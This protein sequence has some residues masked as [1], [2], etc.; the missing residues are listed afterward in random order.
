MGSGAFKGRWSRYVPV[1]AA[2]AAAVPQLTTSRSAASTAAPSAEASAPLGY[3]EASFLSADRQ[4]AADAAADAPRLIVAPHLASASIKVVKK[5]ALM[6]DRAAT[7]QC[8]EKQDLMELLINRLGV[9]RANRQAFEERPDV[10]EA[11]AVAAMLQRMAAESR[12]LVAAM[13]ERHEYA[14]VCL[15]IAERSDSSPRYRTR[16]RRAVEEAKDQVVLV[17]LIA[18]DIELEATELCMTIE[19][20][21]DNTPRDRLPPVKPV[22]DRSLRLLGSLAP[23]AQMLSDFRCWRLDGAAAVEEREQAFDMPSA[24]DTLGASRTWN[25]EEIERLLEAHDVG[26]K[27]PRAKMEDECERLLAE[28]D[29]LLAQVEQAELQAESAELLAELEELQQRHK[30]EVHDVEAERAQ[31]AADL[32]VLLGEQ[33][34]LNREL[35]RQLATMCTILEMVEDERH[36]QVMEVRRL[37]QRF[38]LETL[39]MTP[40][41]LRCAGAML[42]EDVESPSAGLQFKIHPD[43]IDFNVDR[44]FL[45]AG[46]QGVVRKGIMKK[47][48]QEVAVKSMTL[49][50]AVKRAQLVSEIEGLLQAQGC[51]Y[52]VQWVGRFDT[53]LSLTVHVVLEYMDLGSLSDLKARRKNRMLDAPWLWNI[54]QQMVGGLDFLHGKRLLHR[55]IKPQNVLYNSSGEVKLTDFG[56][57]KVMNASVAANTCVGTSLYLSPERCESEEYGF[58]ADIWGAGIVFH[59]MAAG[60]HPFASSKSFIEVW[61]QLAYK[62]EPRLDPGVHDRVLCDFVAACLVRDVSRRSKTIGLKAHP[63]LVEPRSTRCD[64]A[65]WLQHLD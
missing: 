10:R 57:S 61:N 30:H 59:E 63:F 16:L 1:E 39:T 29:D 51:P 5:L 41:D 8:F 13:E 40:T 12:S 15:S 52:L 60:K 21:F 24:E 43:D 55:D 20:S 45:G 23:V 54:A 22:A 46:A 2:E 27:S 17:G 32:K 9:D 56:I 44:D 19:G 38:E 65:R 33:D 28:G 50:S 49:D 48:G 47:T 25:L 7:Q 53:Q 14:G 11:L 58:P 36:T 26:S 62:P 4:L 6:Q 35:D 34:D 37:Q 42:Q 18:K 3:Q 64:F 31:A